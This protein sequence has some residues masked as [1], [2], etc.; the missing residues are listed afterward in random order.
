MSRAEQIACLFW[1]VRFPIRLHGGDRLE[2]GH[3][4]RPRP[5]LPSLW[6][7]GLAGNPCSCSP[8][9]SLRCSLPGDE[10][11]GFLW[12]G[13]KWRRSLSVVLAVLVYALLLPHLGYLIATFILMVVLFSLYDRKKWGH[14]GAGQPSGDR[15]HLSGLSRLAEG[16]ISHGLFQ[17]WL[18]ELSPIHPFG[19][20]IRAAAG[21]PRLLLSRCPPR[22]PH[23]R[24]ARHWS[25][26][27]HLHPSAHH[28]Q[29]PPHRG[30]HHAGRDL[31]RRPV[32]RID[33]LDPL[34]HSRRGHVGDHLSGRLP[35]GPAGPGRTG[36]GHGGH[37]LFH[38]RDP[39]P[40]GADLSGCSVH[41]FCHSSSGP[42][43]ISP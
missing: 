6:N 24:P 17:D 14:C 29:D 22:D 10:A 32:R 12:Q 5:R 1:I 16:S 39:E 35:D 23:R 11:E 43:N 27:H 36:P 13:V 7:R 15:S 20:S 18:M 37:G 31:L 4:F 40:L 19:I 26:G 2:T 30:H 33:H 3:S 25:R 41:R 42:R 8:P 21:K 28:L 9:E 34:K 38:R